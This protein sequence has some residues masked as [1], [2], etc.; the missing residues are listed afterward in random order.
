MTHALLAV[1]TLAVASPQQMRFDGA[2]RTYRVYRPANLPR[3][4]AVPL[5]VMLHG[6]FGDG[7]QAERAY[8]WDA[9]ADRKGFVV[10]YPDGLYRAWN[11]GTCC[12]RPMR[13]SVDDVGFLTA[14]VRT[15]ITDQK[16]DPTRIAFTGMSNGAIM[17][18]RMVCESPLPI[19]AIGSVSGTMLVPCS[20]PQRTRVIEIHGVDDRNIPYN[21][22]R[23]SGPGSILTPPI[24]SIVDRWMQ[25]D[26]CS[27]PQTL[28]QGAVTAQKADC[29]GGNAVEFISIA[30]AGHQWPG[31]AP[32]RLRLF[33]QPSTALNATDTLY[34]FFAW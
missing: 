12:G 13:E 32:P 4:R 26:G 27:S 11:G 14:L 19:S 7:A 34:Q 17:S 15:I 8:G 28:T 22:G 16:I 21:G 24:A 10:V 9:E 5:V 25:I 3:D 29:L 33:D 1:A 31:S 23:G 18:Y 30:N 6:G 2:T 20:H